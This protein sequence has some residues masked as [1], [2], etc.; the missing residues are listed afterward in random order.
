MT[1]QRRRSHRA[2]AA[3]ILAI[4]SQ[5]A[6]L[7]TP[8][9]PA[10]AAGKSRPILVAYV[11]VNNN[12]LANVARYTLA[13]NGANVF[14]I[15]II[16]AAN[17]NY[18]GTSA[19]L[20]YNTQVQAVLNN[21]ATEIA[22]LHAKGIK[23]YLSIL[24]NHQG[25]GISNFPDQASAA[26]FAQQLANAETQY[27]LDGIDFDDEY[28]DYGVN[29]T[30]QPNAWSFPYLVQAL[31]TDAPTKDISRYFYGPATNSLS[32]GTI[33]VGSLLNYSWNAIYGI[34]NP[35]AVSGMTSAQLSPAAIDIQSTSSSVA[36][37]LASRTVRQGYGAYM[38]YNLPNGDDHTYISS[39]TQ[40]LY[41]SA[42]I[43]N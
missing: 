9:A 5:L 21:Q 16:F 37:S 14:S 36:A 17:I 18:N 24:G 34:W 29:G 33:N 15:G 13:S 8:S 10:H 40:S 26:A 11:E 38:T 1:S 35:P 3:L 41:G 28:A 43:Y 27:N 20:F 6:V 39:F 31:R 19:Y 12:D 25:A 7:H 30:G 2:A 23:V 42:A 22:P 4:G 32:Y